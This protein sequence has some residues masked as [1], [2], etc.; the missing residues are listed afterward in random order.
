MSVLPKKIGLPSAV[1]VIQ[2]MIIAP[3]PIIWNHYRMQSPSNVQLILKAVYQGQQGRRHWGCRCCHGNTNNSRPRPNPALTT[4]R[5]RLHYFEKKF[6]ATPKKFSWRR[7]CLP[8]ISTLDSSQNFTLRCTFQ[9]KYPG[10]NTLPENV[11]LFPNAYW[12]KREGISTP[13]STPRS[14]IFAMSL[15]YLYTQDFT[16]FTSCVRYILKSFP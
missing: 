2:N 16:G 5:P 6:L 15:I 11:K 7:A 13:A 12:R 3:P 14:K 4:P 9:H 8:D 1:S 10:L